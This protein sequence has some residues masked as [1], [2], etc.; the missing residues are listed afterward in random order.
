MYLTQE[1]KC[2]LRMYLKANR[3]KTAES[4]SEAYE[5]IEEG[6][7]KKLMKSVLDKITSMD[8]EGFRNI[9]EEIPMID[10]E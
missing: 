8:E 1:E 10:Q 9:A 6:P 5:I 2:I 4:I 7:E 3:E